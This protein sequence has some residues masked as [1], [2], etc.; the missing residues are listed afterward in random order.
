V[1]RVPG[2]AAEV[3]TVPLAVKD[4]RP[5]RGAFGVL[6][7]EPLARH[8]QM[9]GQAGA[10]LSGRRTTLQ[11]AAGHTARAR[12]ALPCLHPRRSGTPETC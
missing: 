6:D 2:C 10:C 7:C 8:R 9:E 12:T 4:L 5:L 1:V 3:M 11:S